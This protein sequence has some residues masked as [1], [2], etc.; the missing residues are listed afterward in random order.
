MGFKDITGNKYGMLTAVKFIEMDYTGI[1]GKSIW[2]FKCDCGNELTHTRNEI[3]RKRRESG[4]MSCGC[5]RTKNI[6]NAVKKP[7]GSAAA[8]SLFCSYKSNATRR[9]YTF[10]LNYEAFLKLTKQNCYYCDKVPSSKLLRSGY[11]GEYIYN[12]IDRYCNREG[13]THNNSV[14]CCWTCNRMKSDLNGEEFLKIIK[15]IYN[16]RFSI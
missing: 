11:N 10:E 13:Y 4:V 2:L 9:G 1:T 3:T 16:N 12:G 6:S 15:S 5:M 8:K 14:S 7:V